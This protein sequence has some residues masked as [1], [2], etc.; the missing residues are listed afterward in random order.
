MARPQSTRRINWWPEHSRI[1]V[2]PKPRIIMAARKQA[3]PRPPITSTSAVL[4]ARQPILFVVKIIITL[5]VVGFVGTIG[6]GY[7]FASDGP[8]G[9]NPLSDI[10]DAINSGPFAPL[11]NVLPYIG[12]SEF[13][14]FN[15]EQYYEEKTAGFDGNY[16]CEATTT[17]SLGIVK[18][19]GMFTCSSN[20]CFIVGE[21]GFNGVI[22]SS[23]TFTGGNV[24]RTDPKGDPVDIIPIN[25]FFS[26]TSKFTLRGSGSGFNQV[27][28]CE[29]VH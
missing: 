22:D 28:I 7:F 24:V 23:G 20:R 3:Q 5:L 6:I 8:V 12:P 15:Q 11:M 25:G 21:R 13:G 9:K 10:A 1:R 16:N 4:I 18:T 19:A 27:F 14:Q 29:K 2:R 17:S 26:L